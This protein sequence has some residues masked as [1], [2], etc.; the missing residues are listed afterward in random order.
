MVGTFD[1]FDPEDVAPEIGTELDVGDVVDE[2]RCWD[3]DCHGGNPVTTGIFAVFDEA[4]GVVIVAKSKSSH[5]PRT[6]SPLRWAVSDMKCEGLE[7]SSNV[8][9][10]SSCWYCVVSEYA[11]KNAIDPSNWTL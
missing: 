2:E 10:K 4:L 6:P 11:E 3:S 1:D 9:E 7:G 5:L 8:C